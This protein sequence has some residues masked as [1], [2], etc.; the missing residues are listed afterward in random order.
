MATITITIPDAVATRAIN[1]FCKRFNYSPTLADGSPNPE[2]KAQFTKRKV[3]EWTKQMIR[4]AEVQDASNTAATE[5]A[6]SV[7][8]DIVLS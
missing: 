2:T 4:E 6:Q 7:D 8:N 1:S 5:A 3:L